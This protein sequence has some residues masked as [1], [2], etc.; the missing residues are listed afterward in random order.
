MSR[1]INWLLNKMKGLWMPKTIA[2][3]NPTKNFAKS[4]PVTKKKPA[5]VKKTGKAKK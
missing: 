4:K 5:P 1:L 3:L 2:E